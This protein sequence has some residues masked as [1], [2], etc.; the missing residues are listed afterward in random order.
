MSLLC[1]IAV[2]WGFSYYVFLL[3]IWGVVTMYSSCLLGCSCFVFYL[4][5]E[6]VVTMYSCCVFGVELLCILV[7]CW[8]VVILCFLSV[9]WG[10]N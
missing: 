3:C 5:S 2:Y 1:I 8:G 10:C 6:G 7:V 9:Y 4:H